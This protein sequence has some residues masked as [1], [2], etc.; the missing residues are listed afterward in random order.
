MV[1]DSSKANS[2]RAHAL[3]R[4]AFSRDSFGGPEAVLDGVERDFDAVA[5]HDL[6]LAGIVLEL[7]DRYD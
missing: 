6:D 3:A 2:R 1:S 5:H 4:L 7:L